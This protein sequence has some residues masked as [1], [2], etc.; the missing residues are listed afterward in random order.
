MLPLFSIMTVAW[1][2]KT[3]NTSALVYRVHK[4]HFIIMEQRSIKSKKWNKE[5]CRTKNG[6]KKHTEQE[7]EQRSRARNGKKKHAE[8]EMEQRSRARNGTKKRTE[9]EM[10]QRSR[11]RNGTKK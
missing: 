8:Q 2:A 5:P 3:E 6:T 10:E 11:A 1:T 7:I 9:Q 4:G